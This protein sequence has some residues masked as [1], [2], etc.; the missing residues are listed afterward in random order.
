MGT[1]RLARGDRTYR[2]SAVT[3]IIV[4]GCLWGAAASLWSGVASA[5]MPEKVYTRADYPDWLTKCPNRKPDFKGG[6]VLPAKDFGA[7]PPV[8]IPSLPDFFKFPNLK[9]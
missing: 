1:V 5:Q 8:V 2:S 9:M 3:V 6:R 7:I 4:A